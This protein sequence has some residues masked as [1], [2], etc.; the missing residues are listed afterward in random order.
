MGSYVF[1]WGNKQET[2]PTWYSMFLED[3]SESEIIDVMQHSW[4]GKWPANKAPSIDAFTINGKKALDNIYL[5]PGS[6]NKAEAIFV[7]PEK[8]ALTIQWVFMPESTDKKAGGDFEKTPE[9]VN[10]LITESKDATIS[11][12][13]PSKPGAYRLYVY[14]YDNDKNV[15]FGN[16]PFYVNA[17]K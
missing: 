14:A 15:A 17:P 11:F 1:L 9:A 6:I 2:T 12:K 5:T 4:S 7:D 8:K 10:D 13:T 3:G 16:I